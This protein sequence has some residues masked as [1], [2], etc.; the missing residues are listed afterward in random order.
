MNCKYFG[1]CGSCTLYDKTYEEQLDFKREREKERFKEITIKAY[2]D[3]IK[4]CDEIFKI[5]AEEILSKGKQQKKVK[6][7]LLDLK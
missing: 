3:I 1:Q 4:S 6:E 2:N 7:I 5:D